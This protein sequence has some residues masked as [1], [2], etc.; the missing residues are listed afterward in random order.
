[1]NPDELA[2][3]AAANAEEVERVRQLAEAAPKGEST[4]SQIGDT[5]VQLDNLGQIVQIAGQVGGFLWDTTCAVGSGVGAVCE[6]VSS[7]VPD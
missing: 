7:I 4:L 3:I 1:M 5:A 6:A 2:A